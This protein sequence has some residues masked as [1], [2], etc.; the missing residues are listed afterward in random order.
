MSF[1][2]CVAV[3][4]AA[5]LLVPAAPL[6]A[7][8]RMGDRQLAQGRVHED[9]KEWD[10][11]VEC[12]LK[13]LDTDPA[14]LDYQMAV[15]KAKFQAAQAHI[16]EGLRIRAQGRLAE[17]LLEFQKAF[18]LNPS[19][20]ASGQELQRTQEMIQ[21]ERQRMQESGKEAPAEVRGMT[22]IEQL[23]K[24]VEQRIDRI[25]PVPD[26]KPLNTTPINW[27]I[28]GQT[29]KVL[30]ETVGAIAGITVLWDPDYAN[31]A[32]NSLNV[33]F[34]NA[35][36]EEALNYVALITKSFWKP[37]SS[38]TVFITNDSQNKRHDYEDQVSQV[39]YLSNVNQAQE[40][41]EIVNVVRS[42]TEL[43]RISAYNSQS[44]IVVRGEADK[45]ALAAA[46]IHDLDKPRAEVLV[47]I[48]VLETNS[49]FNRSLSAAIASG[50]INAGINFTPRSSIQVQSSS[51][52]SSSSSTEAIPISNVGHLSSADFSVTMP[53][54]LLQATLSDT[55]TKV[56]QAPQLRA[57]DGSKADLKIGQREPTASGSYQP[58][59]SSSGVNALVNTQFTY[60]DVGVNVTMLPHIHDN[61]D[62]TLH[63]ELEISNIA[64][65]VNLGGINEPIIGQRKVT[66]DIRLH[67]GEVNLIA[68]LINT[69]DTK[70][71]TGIPGLAS[72]PV[73]GKLFSGNTVDKDRDEIMIAI[74]PH[75][76]RQP[77]IT[78]ENIRAKAVGNSTTVKL[79]Y[80][81]L[82]PEAIETNAAQADNTPPAA[83]SPAGLAPS[84]TAPPETPGLTPPVTAPAMGAT[85]QPGT[86]APT[87]NKKSAGG[88]PS[89]Q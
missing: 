56:L 61:G 8:T 2:L 72:L 4:A 48:L 3:I 12:Y 19:A 74:V 20:V 50:G 16:D 85:P 30:F 58:G 86:P 1:K 80:A 71:V 54:G 25:L 52:S 35:S 82:R 43:T 49:V 15:T 69:S 46:L 67:E 29:A 62:V 26:L 66:H 7:R 44:A 11:A 5:A 9:R 32:K 64:G 31:P 13:A 75:V 57:L 84:P 76:I 24:E 14:D 36:A 63:V 34:K 73:L 37:V 21:R 41:Q 78:P 23:R 81:P 89:G 27:K 6:E 40:I 51:S 22:P 39:F 79:N 33:D 68:G 87:P 88:A 17:A 38:N 77:S 42:V 55:R 83:A 18:A 53:S 60:I 59:S 28:N 10:A 70:T 47:D 65:T 45:V